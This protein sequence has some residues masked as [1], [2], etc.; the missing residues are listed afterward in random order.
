MLAF[1]PLPVLQSL[2][3]L[4][5]AVTSSPALNSDAKLAAFTSM[6][7]MLVGLPLLDAALGQQ[8][9]G[10]AIEIATHKPWAVGQ[11]ARSVGRQPHSQL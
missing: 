5:T 8:R 4:A 3:A 1:L 2:A 11:P 6:D 7:D 10:L 9:Y